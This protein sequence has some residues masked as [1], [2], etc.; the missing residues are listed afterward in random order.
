MKRVFV[1]TQAKDAAKAVETLRDLGIVHVEHERLPAG[2]DLDKTRDELDLLEEAI[3][4]IRNYSDLKKVPM[5]NVA[6][7]RRTT[8]EILGV[9]D[10]LENLTLKD[11]HWQALI[12]QLEPWG[13]FDPQ[14]LQGLSQAGIYVRLY[15]IPASEMGKLP[16]DVIVQAVS[17][18]K[19]IM[20]AVVVSR[21]E[22]GLSF[23]HLVLPEVGLAEAR[24]RK[25][26]GLKKISEFKAQLQEYSNALEGLLREQRKKLDELH[27]QEAL[28]GMGR[29]E[30]LAFLKGFCPIDAVARLEDAATKHKWAVLAED[31]ADE[32][33]PPTLLR[34][35]SWVRLVN[36]I[37][38]FMNI[39]PG[40]READVSLCFLLFFSVFF[41]ILI[42]DAGYGLIFLLATM[43]AKKK[44]GNKVDPAPFQLMMILSGCTII[45]GIL[46]GTFFG[47][48]LF[49]KV[50]RPLLPWL[51]NDI[52]MQQL[53][54]VI[55]VTHLTIAHVWRGIRKWPSYRAF[56]EIGWLSLVWASYFLA[57]NMLFNRPLPGF[58]RYLFYIGPALIVLF[59]Q[60]RKN[61]FA[62]VGLGLGDLFLSVM[63]MFV[64]LLSYIRLFAV[65]LA[66]LL[67][68]DSFNQ[69][70]SPMNA[71]NF[72][73]GFFSALILVLMHVLNMALG[74]I[75]V[76]VHGLRL[77]IF[78]FS[79]H[80]GI[81]W[82]GSKY[83]P[84]AKTQS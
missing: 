81:E 71:P 3:S 45:W 42:G 14:E 12:E 84:L 68:A 34:Q 65:G 36:P 21:S 5:I 29:A 25:E 69:M 66:G 27:F 58:V 35:P 49:G 76:L 67:L 53:C 83:S 57:R 60:P 75:A 46:T 48:A 70:L 73:A 23:P 38:D 2:A 26:A 64:D 41:G 61:F 4:T 31:P 82:S 6:D 28:T 30:N 54:F 77:N 7:W 63:S 59:N 39:I 72:A 13:E 55:G 50:V 33:R 44:I 15:E 8:G 32:D 80:L 24:K 19:D 11:R 22:P 18:K 16:L 51:R 37:F 1:L 78:E 10:S 20:Y 79:S 9:G 56:S 52:N 43:W 74:L 62:R 47:Q 40:Y 17:R